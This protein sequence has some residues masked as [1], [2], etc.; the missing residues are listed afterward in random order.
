M[1]DVHGQGVVLVGVAH[2]DVETRRRETL[3]RGGVPGGGQHRF[4]GRIRHP[5]HPDG[6]PHATEPP[7]PWNWSAQS[8]VPLPPSSTA[9]TPSR[10]HTGPY[11][12]PGDASIGSH[13][14]AM[15][16][17][18]APLPVWSSPRESPTSS[19]CY[20][21]GRGTTVML[22]VGGSSHGPTAGVRAPY[23]DHPFWP[24]TREEFYRRRTAALERAR[25]WV[26]LKAAAPT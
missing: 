2:V 12:S 11:V 5:N 10:Q 16:G 14:G 24:R 15:K 22:L 3:C 19:T 25:E 18:G 1:K 8:R 26:P 20:P 7:L 6:G 13:L 17:V 23:F 4:D 21:Q 9:H